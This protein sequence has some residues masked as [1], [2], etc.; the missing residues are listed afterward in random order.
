MFLCLLK[1]AVRKVYN[2]E[3]NKERNTERM[4]K[5]KRGGKKLTCWFGLRRKGASEMASCAEV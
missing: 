4:I 2:K 3:R 1:K 5:D